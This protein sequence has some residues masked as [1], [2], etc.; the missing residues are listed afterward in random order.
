METR[1]LGRYGPQV[2]VFGL[3]TMTFGAE[4]DAETSHDILDHYYE[5]GGRFIDTADVYTHGVSEQ[6]IGQW[7]QDRGHD[8]IVVATKARFAMGDEPDDSGAG[9][10]HIFKAI[11]ASL[12]RLRVETVDLFQMHAWDP[13]VPM[14]ETLAALNELVD[15]GKVRYI[16]VSN[17]LG[18]QLERAVQ[19]G[20]QAGLSPIVSLQPQY[21]LLARDIE[22]DVMPVALEHGIGL[23]PWSPLGGGWLAGKY[24]REERP[25]GATRLGE[26]PGRGVEAYD[27]RNT[28]FTWRILDLAGSISEERGVAMGEVALNWLRARPGVASVLLG[29]RTV[30]QLS[31]NLAALQWAMT[32]EEVDALNQVS[33]PG[34]PDYPYGFLEEYAGMDIWQEL[35]AGE[36]G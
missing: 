36:A 28:E 14:E 8:D 1:A 5:S 9:R 25:T 11:D 19:V 35:G 30:D 21:N 24:E 4:A 22:L 31:Q 15:A 29:A 34:V 32:T 13:D 7:L 16:G 3:G 20:R 10:G 17:Y 2:S 27:K 23:L 33:A 26:D 6:I 18:W 12:E